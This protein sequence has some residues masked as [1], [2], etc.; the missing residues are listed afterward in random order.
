MSIKIIIML[1]KLFE[2]LLFSW[3][4]ADTFI[5]HLVLASQKAQKYIFPLST[6]RRE[7]LGSEE[8]LN[9]FQITCPLLR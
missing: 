4:W 7:N 3:H 5:H 1:L 8:E 2:C 9:F 6:Y